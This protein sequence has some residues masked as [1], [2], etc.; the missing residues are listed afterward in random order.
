MRREEEELHDLHLERVSFE[1]R[2]VPSD[3][4]D[5]CERKLFAVG[6]GIDYQQRGGE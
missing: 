3:C 2:V 4:T 5:T 1:I 6:V